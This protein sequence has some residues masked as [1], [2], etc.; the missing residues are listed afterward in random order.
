MYDEHLQADEGTARVAF[1]RAIAAGILS[2]NP[3]AENFAGGFM[4]MG[5]LDEGDAFKHI[6]T[7]QYVYHKRGTAS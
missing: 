7:R 5:A 4:F 3:K 6:D 2:E 1:D